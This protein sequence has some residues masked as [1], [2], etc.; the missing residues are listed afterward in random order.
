MSVSDNDQDGFSYADK[1]LYKSFLKLFCNHLFEYDDGNLG[2]NL[3]LET[4][5]AYDTN[6]EA[7]KQTLNDII[8]A[9]GALVYFPRHRRGAVVEQSNEA[10][11]LENTKTI[12]EN[13]FDA[14]DLMDPPRQAL[15]ID[16]CLQESLRVSSRRS[17]EGRFLQKY[18][19]Q[20][21]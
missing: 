16:Q 10:I 1:R 20:E 11:Y 18:L 13:V 6:R 8:R 12:P 9:F 17:S 5:G 3:R 19:D 14:L 7:I 15:L 4:F 21:N 2:I